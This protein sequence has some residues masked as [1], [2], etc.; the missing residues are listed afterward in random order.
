[1]G[2]QVRTFCFQIPEIWLRQ[3]SGNS[4]LHQMPEQL[5]HFQRV[6]YIG[7][8][9]PG[10]KQG[11]VFIEE[12]LPVSAYGFAVF[13]R[14]VGI[15]GIKYHA[16]TIVHIGKTTRLVSSVAKAM[17]GHP[18]VGFAG[19]LQKVTGMYGENS[20]LLHV[21][22]ITGGTGLVIYEG[23]FRFYRRLYNGLRRLFRRDF[24]R[25]RVRYGFFCMVNHFLFMYGSTE[26]YAH[27]QFGSL[28]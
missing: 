11:A 13:S 26:G 1:M 3:A 6:S 16:D 25:R 23:Q 12:H 19:H 10:L 17:A 4:L 24:H 9:E 22:G 27:R 21:L 14:N 15:Y 28:D 20:D 8:I 2:V 18:C 7:R 5:G